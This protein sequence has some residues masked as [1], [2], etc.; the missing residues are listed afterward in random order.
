MTRQSR[1]IFS[2]EKRSEIM[3]AVKSRDT[4]PEI[5]LRKALFGMGLRYRVN[6]RRLPGSPDI[7]FAKRRAIIFVHGC[8]WHGHDCKRGARVPKSNSAYWRRKIA[9][10]TA[11]DKKNVAAL[12]KDGWRVKI[13]WECRLKDLSIE[14]NKIAGWVL[15]RRQ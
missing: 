4:K 15:D 7:V 3:R 9:A 14:A 5:A 13:I 11:R 12:Q 1:D 10:N 8:F 2:P 6:V